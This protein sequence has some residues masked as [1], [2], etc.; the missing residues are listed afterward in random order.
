MSHPDPHA[1][2]PNQQ[3]QLVVVQDELQPCH[4]RDQVARMPLRVPMGNVTPAAVDEM[5]MLGYR[6]SGDFVYRTQ[7][8]D[9]SACEPTRIA[10]QSFALTK[11]MKRVLKRGDRDLDCVIDVPESESERVRLFNDHRQRRNLGDRCDLIDEDAYRSFVVASCFLTLEIAIY[12][13]GQLVAVSIFD[14]G[15]ESVSA[16]Y[17]F[18]D[19]SFHRYSLGTYA[20]LKQLEWAKHQKIRFLYL[21]M[22][23]EDNRHLNYKSRFQPQQRL[24]NG[25]WQD[26]NAPSDIAMF[27]NNK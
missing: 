10:A 4:Y 24:I 26:F 23:V 21:G 7:C 15:A 1:R 18:F 3:I 13:S 22:F 2:L 19:Q 9:C 17:T 14:V 25:E 20:I 5:L 8:P 27:Q 6:R 12:H 11:S 16:F